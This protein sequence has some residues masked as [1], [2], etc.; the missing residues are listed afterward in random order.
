MSS[1]D[2]GP[3]FDEML[4]L[5]PKTSVKQSQQEQGGKPQRPQAYDPERI[6]KVIFAI[7][8]LLVFLLCIVKRQKIKGILTRIV[9]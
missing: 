1:R 6:K 8:G 2:L 5:K 9:S 4:D 7:A 3:I